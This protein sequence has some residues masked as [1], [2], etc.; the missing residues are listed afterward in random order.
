MADGL[1][2]SRMASS[3]ADILAELA[4]SSRVASHQIPENHRYRQ[5]SSPPS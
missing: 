5:K 3:G 1:T 2:N 4:A